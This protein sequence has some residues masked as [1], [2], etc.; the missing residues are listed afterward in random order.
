MADKFVRDPFKVKISRI[1]L[2]SI[3]EYR[4]AKRTWMDGSERLYGP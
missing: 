3:G 2:E 1:A 4:P